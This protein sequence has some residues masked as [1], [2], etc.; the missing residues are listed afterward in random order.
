MQRKKDN[1]KNKKISTDFPKN[2]DELLESLSNTIDL[3]E[4]GSKYQSLFAFALT[5]SENIDDYENLL[6]LILTAAIDQFAIAETGSIFLLHQDGDR[7]VL[8]RKRG[9]HEKF[10]QFTE[11]KIGQGI[12]GIVAQTGKTILI[13]KCE[14]DLRYLP[15]RSRAG[16]LRS[17]LCVPMKARSELLGVICLHNSKKEEGFNDDD[18]LVVEELAKI[19]AISV[20][21]SRLY[22]NV[23][24][25]SL[26]DTLT[27]LPNRRGIEAAFHENI[28]RTI[29]NKQILSVIFIDIDNLKHFNDTFGYKQGDQVILSVASSIKRNIF[30]RDI[31]GKWK[32]GDEFIIILPGTNLETAQIVAQRIREDVEKRRV[33]GLPDERFTVS[34][35]VAQLNENYDNSVN[36]VEQ[37]ESAKNRAKKEGKNKVC[38]YK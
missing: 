36:V 30:N 27:K 8:I 6:D 18:Q 15:Y 22:N 33:T 29:K 34:I 31:P 3:L 10:V 35:G 14:E 17:I 32:E 12:A 28:E 1:K 25:A 21:N 26:T 4:K 38:L 2:L 19:A 16:Q 24:F 5:T 20:S 9:L 37:A 13:N 11:F 7:I 23:V